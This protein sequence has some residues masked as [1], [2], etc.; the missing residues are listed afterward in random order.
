MRTSFYRTCVIEAST[1]RVILS[2]ELKR[3][4]ELMFSPKDSFFL[5]WEPYTTYNNKVSTILGN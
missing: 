3:T 1:G 5:T 2:A 4:A